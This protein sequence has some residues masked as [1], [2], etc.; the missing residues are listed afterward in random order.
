MGRLT[1]ITC[2]DSEC[3]G[4]HG[5]NEMT[6]LTLTPRYGCEHK[7]NQFWTSSRYHIPARFY[8]KDMGPGCACGHTGIRLAVQIW[9]MEIGNTFIFSRVEEQILLILSAS[10]TWRFLLAGWSCSSK[11]HLTGNKYRSNRCL[12][13]DHNFLCTQNLIKTTG[14]IHCSAVFCFCLIVVSCHL[15][16]SERL[17][18]LLSRLE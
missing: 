18:K 11:D 9:F 17:Q 10:T 16:V 14:F 4:F 5:L 2:T 6:R 8:G 7:K 12:G 3:F 15:V 1:K 13:L